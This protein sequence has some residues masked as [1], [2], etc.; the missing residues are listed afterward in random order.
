M[1]L[2][3]FYYTIGPGLLTRP[4]D[5]TVNSNEHLFVA[6]SRSHLSSALHLMVLIWEGLT[7]VNWVVQ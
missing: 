6:D 5:V 7:K 1:L 3:S 2:I 4:W